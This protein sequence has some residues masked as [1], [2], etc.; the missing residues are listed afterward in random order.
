L[1]TKPNETL[2]HP[3]G[4]GELDFKFM[5]VGGQFHLRCS[6]EALTAYGGLVAWD[7]FMERCGVIAR[8][9]AHTPFTVFPSLCVPQEHARGS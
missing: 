3:V 7:H 1:K 2:V 9:A 8:R 6:D 5:P 4:E